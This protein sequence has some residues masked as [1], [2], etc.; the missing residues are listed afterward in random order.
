MSEWNEMEVEVDPSELMTRLQ[1]ERHQQR[2]MEEFM[3]P[4]TMASNFEMP[5]FPNGG[6]AASAWDPTPELTPMGIAEL[7]LPLMGY[8]EVMMMW[9]YA[10]YDIYSTNPAVFEDPDPSSYGAAL[11]EQFTQA[12]FPPS[13]AQDLVQYI[14]SEIE[15]E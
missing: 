1:D 13:A 15:Y 4:E 2:Q 8:Q 11:M 12:G 14:L 9:S 3:D 5:E 7:E 6:T 10:V